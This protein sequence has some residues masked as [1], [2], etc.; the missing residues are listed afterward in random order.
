MPLEW[1]A[2][3]RVFAL[4]EWE[5]LRAADPEAT[6][7]HTSR[8]LRIYWE[9]LGEGTPLVAI[10]RQGDEPIGLCGFQVRDG[11][12]SF[13]GGFEVTDYLGPIGRPEDRAR[14]AKEVTTALAARDDWD[15]ADLEGLPQ[16]GSWL[17]ALADAAEAAG[18]ATEVGE[19]DVAP[20]LD[21]PADW[22]AYLAGLKPKQRHEIRRKERRLGERFP[23]AR[24][25]RS[26]TESF[27]ADLDRF[28]EMHRASEG[29]K[30]RFMSEDVEP[31][32]RRLGS[33]LLPEGILRL[34]FLEGGG[35]KLAGLVAFRFEDTLL[36]YN[37]A[38][39]PRH[40][41]VAPGMVL[42]SEIVKE[43][44]GEGCARL[45]MLKGDLGYKYRF[46]ARPR[47]IRRLLLE[48]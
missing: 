42:V 5:R 6:F 4:D 47:P 21:L 46:G 12:L 2:D 31:F 30:G 34:A 48:R 39:D 23:D 41:A 1:I 11:V 32:F 19:D 38:F 35:E 3:P 36:L 13:L 7:F 18:L 14:V 20:M 37:S 22:D 43:A 27:D 40:R 9:E 28:V 44:I 16:E 33:E 24:L 29:P 17:G 25:T 26:S 15:R 8:F 45:D 10:V